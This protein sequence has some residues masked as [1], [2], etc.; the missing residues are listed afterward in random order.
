VQLWSAT[1][2]AV[3]AAIMAA[4]G[5]CVA[6]Y[7][8]LP[9]GQKAFG[10]WIKRN[11]TG[12]LI[13]VVQGLRDD[14]NTHAEQLNTVAQTQRVNHEEGQ[15]NFQR[16]DETANRLT[17]ALQQTNDRIRAYTEEHMAEATGRDNA[18]MSLTQRLTEFGERL[19]TVA[20]RLLHH[21]N[22]RSRHVPRPRKVSR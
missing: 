13:T 2:A 12:D 4:G 15:A 6:V 16:I 8:N 17:D 18:I 7:V 22:S 11:L 3:C 9:R 1:I 21:E 20:D 14:L 19:A 10:A 5:L